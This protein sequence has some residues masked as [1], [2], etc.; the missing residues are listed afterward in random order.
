MQY[1]NSLRTQ[2]PLHP[3]QVEAIK[4]LQRSLA[5]NRG[6][7]ISVLKLPTGAGKTR[8]ANELVHS[9]LQKNP[10]S[11]V[12]WV[13]PNWEL[14]LQAA[15]AMA[16]Y[17]PAREQMRRIGGNG[18]TL[19]QY[20]NEVSQNGQRGRIHYTTLHT[21]NNRHRGRQYDLIV[22]DESHWG[23]TGYMAD[24]FFDFHL[25]RKRA[26]LGLSA[27]P[28]Q[29]DL[30]EICCEYSYAQLANQ[31]YLAT[32]IVEQVDTGITWS[33]LLRRDGIII[34]ESFN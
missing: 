16:R 5:Q 14:L 6:Q 13:A 22:Y 21:W 33:P 23:H 2:F 20:I 11:K 28:N 8:V 12:L 4:E 19:A 29:H 26:I 18:K 1:D 3:Y 7:K 9:W 31:G 17:F 10:T 30:M 24:N 32:P 34:E 27:T 15:D 25:E